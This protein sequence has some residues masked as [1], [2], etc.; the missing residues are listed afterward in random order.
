MVVFM[1]FETICRFLQ[2]RI[3]GHRSAAE[4]CNQIS[5]KSFFDIGC[6]FSDKHK[7]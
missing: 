2:K 6:W 3:L 7:A 5:Q 4:V 1:T